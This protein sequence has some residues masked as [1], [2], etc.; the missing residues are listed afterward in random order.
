MVENAPQSGECRTDAV[1]SIYGTSEEASTSAKNLKNTL[2]EFGISPHLL[3]GE[4]WFI[5]APVA[6][7]Y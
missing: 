5:N 3:L 6:S 7:E 4:N 1:L 2:A